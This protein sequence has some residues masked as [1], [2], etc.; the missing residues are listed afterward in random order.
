M[1]LLY[2]IIGVLIGTMIM[3]L[4]VAMFD[5][6]SLGFD[7]LSAL[8][9][10]IQNLIHVTYS[11][12]YILLN[13]IFLVFMIIFLRNQIGI[14][15]IINYL[16]TGVFCDIFIFLFKSINLSHSPYLLVNIVYGLIGVILLALGIAVY[17]NANLGITPY[18]SMPIIIT[19]YV[20]L[21]N[22]PVKFHVA[23]KII[24][25]I[26]LMLALII[27]VIILKYKNIIGINT[28]VLLILVGYLISFFSKI[29]NKYIYKTNTDMFK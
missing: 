15:T 22:K 13:L 10:S 19:K 23:R 11:I 28:I 26:C 21:F 6:S 9:I 24:D 12:A 8:V 16:L 3:G 1:K 14:G 5:L 2:R 17:A 29:V 20:K 4:G 18:D 25:G 27:G 7:A